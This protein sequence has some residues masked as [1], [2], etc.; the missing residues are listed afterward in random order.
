MENKTNLKV[1]EIVEAMECS[2]YIAKRA[3]VLMT[4]AIEDNEQHEVMEKLN[5][6]FDCHGVESVF[7]N[8]FELIYYKDY[9][10]N[11][12]YLNTGDSYIGTIILEHDK[13]ILSSW[14]DMVEDAERI[15]SEKFLDFFPKIWKNL[16]T[17][18]KVSI[19]VFANENVETNE[20]V[21][22]FSSRQKS[23]DFLSCIPCDFFTP[24]KE[25]MEE[26]YT[27]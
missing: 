25:A 2:E 7:C 9:D 10:S 17:N 20:K 16:M 23:N 11:A 13:F 22:I 1:S 4:R 21:S 6:L 12:Q 3:I 14:G 8:D 5:S 15:D 26:Y 24:L 18:E 19:I 27:E